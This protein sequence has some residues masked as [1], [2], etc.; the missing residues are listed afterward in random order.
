MYK[1]IFF[2]L[3]RQFQ[4]IKTTDPRDNAVSI[5]CLAIFFHS[6]LILGILDY[7]HLNLFRL[8]FGQQQNKYYWTPVIVLI[9]IFV[10]RYFNK[11]RT[12]KIILDFE[13]KGT[14]ANWIN[15]VIALALTILPLVIGIQF[16][17]AD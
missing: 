2:I 9:M 14:M 4:K 13:T 6:F 8:A 15:T 12:D 10:W 11:E 1:F 16:L 3:Y 17:N 7:F 5:V